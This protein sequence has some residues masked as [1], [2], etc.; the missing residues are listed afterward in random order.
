MPSAGRVGGPAGQ[1]APVRGSGEVSEDR[2]L[3]F[4]LE[5]SDGFQLKCF[6]GSEVIIGRNT[7]RSTDHRLSRVH[8]LATAERP[9][10]L[11]IDFRGKHAGTLIRRSK[12]GVSGASDRLT[13]GMQ[14]V[15]S[16]GDR[17]TPI[18]TSRVT[19]TVR[20][21]AD[22][23]ERQSTSVVEGTGSRIDKKGNGASRV[24]VSVSEHIDAPS[25]VTANASIHSPTADPTADPTAGQTPPLTASS[26]QWGCPMCTMLNPVD[27]D[28]CS[29]CM[30]LSPAACARP[31]V[32]AC[33]VCAC[34]HQ[35][36][37]PHCD[38]CH[39]PNPSAQLQI[40]ESKESDGVRHLAQDGSLSDA[41]LARALDKQ[42]RELYARALAK[43]QGGGAETSAERRRRQMLAE[44]AILIRAQRR[45]QAAFDAQA[46]ATETA[47]VDE[48][49]AGGRPREV[50][51]SSTSL[52]PLVSNVPDVAPRDIWTRNSRSKS[53]FGMAKKGAFGDAKAKKKATN[54][55]R[56]DTR[57]CFIPLDV[58]SSE[59]RQ[60]EEQFIKTAKPTHAIVKIEAVKNPIRLGY[61]MFK[62]QQFQRV[63]GDDWLNEMWLWHGTGPETIRMIAHQGFLR[64][65]MTESKYGKGV[66]L[67]SSATVASERAEPD[68][69]GMRRMFLAR[70]L[71]GHYHTGYPS[72]LL[73]DPKPGR[74]FQVHES[75]VDNVA[76]PSYF[77]LFQDDQA[78][79]EYCVTFRTVVTGSA[80]RPEQ[81]QRSAHDPTDRTLQDVGSADGKEGTS[82]HGEQCDDD[83]DDDD[84]GGGGDDGS[85]VEG[86]NQGG[87][88][89]DA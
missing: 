83:D 69:V 76:R 17:I 85:V 35:K 13:R 66:S 54:A 10:V 2:G 89:A 59:Y 40:D 61:Y 72:C 87:V 29:V 71:V 39:A 48:A 68:R 55:R 21:V 51:V 18:S 6:Y 47:A 20:L 88:S 82:G 8:V 16:D 78:Y 52:K 36:T 43:A 80:P 53:D 25:E 9:D 14:V 42:E 27:F 81:G 38:V 49:V 31:G 64:Q 12:H 58:K 5:G 4:V 67:A 1:Q 57:V 34:V 70:A 45:R 32:W 77:I 60:V 30:S 15:V 62:R 63:L 79:A 84:G 46:D 73:P 50:R 24:T 3:A 75:V 28:T 19:Y 26:T 86:V 65:F 41:A 74:E 56:A 37:K 11:K 33:V 7:V 44:K 22:Q 23:T